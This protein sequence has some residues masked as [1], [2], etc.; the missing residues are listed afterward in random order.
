MRRNR[1]QSLPHP[2]PRDGTESGCPGAF[3]VLHLRVSVAL[4][5]IRRKATTGQE[6]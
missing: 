3:V 2:C 4:A 1:G 6:R 5:K